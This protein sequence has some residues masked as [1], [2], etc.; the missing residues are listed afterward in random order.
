MVLKTRL[1]R[2]KK[3]V[4]KYSPFP[5]KLIIIINIIL[6]YVQRSFIFKENHFFN[7]K[8]NSLQKVVIV[9]KKL[10]DIDRD[11]IVNLEGLSEFEF[12]DEES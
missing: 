9:E 8:Y 6:D 2:S 1:T 10:D 4:L 12:I 5:N 7:E 11:D 3:F